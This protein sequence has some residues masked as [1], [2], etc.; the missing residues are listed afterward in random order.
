[1]V[2]CWIEL[3]SVSQSI[4]QHW[5]SSRL[6]HLTKNILLLWNSRQSAVRCRRTEAKSVNFAVSSIST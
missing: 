1:V 4:A 6:S 2:L 3:L 5:V